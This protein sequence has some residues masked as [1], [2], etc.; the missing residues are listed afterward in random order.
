MGKEVELPKPPQGKKRVRTMREKLLSS[1]LWA[2]H[3]E[4]LEDIMC[5]FFNFLKQIIFIVFYWS[6]GY[7][8]LCLRELFCW[9]FAVCGKKWMETIGAVCVGI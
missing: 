2:A 5:S 4:R 6:F 8:L 9:L 7:D 3:I 1:H